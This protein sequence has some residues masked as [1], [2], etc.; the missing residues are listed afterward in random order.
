M[1]VR[2]AGDGG[3]RPRDAELDAAILAAAR[4]IAAERGVGGL[5]ISDVADR[6]GTS[7][8]A[9]YRRFASRTDLAVATLASLAVA[10]DPTSTGDPLADL[11]AE[12]SDFRAAISRLHSITLVGS[13][14]LEDVADEVVLAYRSGIV[15]PR[16]AALAGILGAARDSGALTADDTDIAVAVTM[17]TGSWYAAALAGVEPPT[18]WPRRTARLVWRALG[19]RTGDGSA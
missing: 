1:D 12:L 10:R 6:A 2:R 19:G 15:D 8:P 16:R 3:G 4:E 11:T 17:C 7:R 5:T 13:M 18:D 9:V 14:L